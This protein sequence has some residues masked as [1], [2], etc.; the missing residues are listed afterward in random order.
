V[1]QTNRFKA[2]VIGAPCVDLFSMY[3]TSDIGVT[4]GEDQWR[5]YPSQVEG[6]SL[7][8]LALHLLRMSPITYAPAVETPLLLLHG[9][10]DLR[11]PISQSEAYFTLLKRLGKDVEMVRFPGCNH[12][13]LRSG[14]PKMR[15]AYLERTLGWF[16]KYL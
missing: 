2:A 13:F 7:E 1:G 12:L 6:R 11:C 5:A 9:E 15:E 16:Q 4:F 14:H 3:G 8:D 10:A